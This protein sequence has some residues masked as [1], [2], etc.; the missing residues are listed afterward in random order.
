M[1]DAVALRFLADENFDRRIVEG[2]RRKQPTIDIQTAKEAGLLGEHERIGRAYAAE[3]G[4]V[5]L[6][7]DT[8]TMPG[9][10]YARLADGQHSPGVLLV[11]QEAPIGPAIEDVLL[12]WD[13]SEPEEWRD[14]CNYL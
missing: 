7:H 1:S 6:S 4:R 3:H 5:L 2:L 14:A 10:L 8:S 9:Y 11:L 13:L 12:V